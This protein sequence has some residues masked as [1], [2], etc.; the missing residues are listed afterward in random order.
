ML[1]F[2]GTSNYLSPKNG[3]ENVL[4]AH[5]WKHL[6]VAEVGHFYVWLVHVGVTRVLLELIVTILTPCKINME[7]ENEPWKRRFL[8]NPSFSGSMLVFGG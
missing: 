1:G 6:A 8:L 7:P 3:D 4:S 2:S 5:I